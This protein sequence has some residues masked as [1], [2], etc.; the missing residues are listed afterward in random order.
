VLPYE[1]E[2]GSGETDMVKL[3]IAGK[4]RSPV[5]IS[6]EIRDGSV[7][8]GW[9]GMPGGVEAVLLEDL[10]RKCGVD[11]TATLLSALGILVTRLNGREDALILTSTGEST[12]RCWAPIKLN[13]AWDSS[14]ASLARQ[15]SDSLAVA[16][17]NGAYALEILLDDLTG[18]KPIFDVAYVERN[19]QDV[20]DNLKS[21]FPLVA[22]QLKLILEREDSKT[23]LNVQ[24]RL[25][26]GD[27]TQTLLKTLTSHLKP[28][29]EQAADNVNIR[30]GDMKLD[31]EN[32][33]SVV[34]DLLVQE[35]FSFGAT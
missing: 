22:Q 24:L 10:S 17:L 35:V 7:E 13:V 21:D 26:K 1:I 16:Q 5:E 12:N 14:F 9:N 19:E 25:R 27:Q 20:V 4:A 3:R 33:I 28:I 31:E 11:V 23:G 32:E 2:P 29:L 18:A 34:P 30:L 8:A 15:V 6:A